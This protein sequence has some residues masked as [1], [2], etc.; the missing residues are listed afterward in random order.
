MANDDQIKLSS[1]FQHSL[2]GAWQLIKVNPKA[3]DYFDL[4]S[5]GFWKSF[6]AIA[7]MLPAFVFWA[8]YNIEYNPYYAFMTELLV[9]FLLL[10][11]VAFVMFFFTKFMNIQ[12]HYPS[13]IIAYNWVNVPIYWIIKIAYI[14]LYSGSISMEIASTVMMVIGFYLSLYVVWATFKLSLK[15]SG[16]LAVGVLVF[17]L[18]LAASMQAIIMR[19]FNPDELSAMVALASNP[20]V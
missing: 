4:S 14:I 6:W 19:I 7:L 17:E 8:L 5:D 10:P 15:I 9:V 1:Y 13:M 11:F 12:D 16:L 18:L 20:P 3:M 2:M